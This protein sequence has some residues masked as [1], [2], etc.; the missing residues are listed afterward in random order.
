MASL[1]TALLLAPSAALAL[2]PTRTAEI[3]EKR[4][5]VSSQIQEKRQAVRA[6]V[7]SVHAERL[8][9]RF[10]VYYTRLSMMIEKVQKRIDALKAEGKDTTAAQAKL[11]EAKIALE[12]A[13]KQADTSVS[14]FKDIDPDKYAE[15]R[16]Q[17]LQARDI[18]ETARELFQKVLRLL[19]EAVSLLKDLR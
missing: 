4:A 9:K 18:A 5:S 2:E 6:H 7:A 11:N 15:Q 10:T 1:A 8:G 13:K 17:A 3:R 19:K 12:S 14:E 16:T